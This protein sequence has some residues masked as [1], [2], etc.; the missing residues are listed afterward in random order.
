[1][2]ILI[3]SIEATSSPRSVIDHSHVKL[4]K[5]I[6][7]D[8]LPPILL[9]RGTMKLVDVL[10]RLHAAKLRGDD[11][12]LAEYFDGDDDAAFMMAV[13]VNSQH[14]L[15]LTLRDR[16]QAARKVLMR[17][18]DWSDRS[19]ASAVGLSNK[20]V[21]RLRSEFGSSIPAVQRRVGM[22]GVAQ[23]VN[24]IEGR[25]RAE[26]VLDRDP[27]A[28]ATEIANRAGVSLTTAKVVRSRWKDRASGSRSSSTPDGENIPGT[29]PSCRDKEDPSAQYY[30]HALRRL[31]SDP[32]IRL[33]QHGRTLFR[34]L[35]P[36]A[37]AE[38]DWEDLA[39]NIPQ[40]CRV[41]VAEMAQLQVRNWARFAAIIA[42][43]NEKAS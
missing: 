9:Q 13:K 34:L 5:H 2:R 27:G 23:P 16:K 19:I 14:G 36:G 24:H 43:R 12:I 33:S 40:H 6:D 29:A 20:T 15:P 7:A 30:K 32:S 35:E 21:S 39:S 28:T 41:I 37:R 18:P 4:L 17:H 38:G 1:M 25:A 31:S 11:T 22:D 10:H 42:D 3:D 26:A 8:A